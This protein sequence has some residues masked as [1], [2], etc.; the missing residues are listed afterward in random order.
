[1]IFFFSPLRTKLGPGFFGFG[2]D[3]L[4]TILPFLNS[5]GAVFFF[6]ARTKDSR[7]EGASTRALSLYL[8]TSASMTRLSSDPF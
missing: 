2:E 3:C 6:L 4:W 5:Q 1:M 8:S 7:L